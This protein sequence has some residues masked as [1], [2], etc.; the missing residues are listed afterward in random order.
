MK[1]HPIIPSDGVEAT[2]DRRTVH[3][4]RHG[5]C[6][7]AVRIP[8]VEPGICSTKPG[9]CFIFKMHVRV[10]TIV[11]PIVE[12]S[13]LQDWYTLFCCFLVMYCIVC[14]IL[15]CMYC[16]DAV[17]C[18]GSLLYDVGRKF[19]FVPKYVAF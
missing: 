8:C 1:L 18:N 10:N 5:S 11:A 15:Y 2:K 9:I 13:K 16:I 7:P 12:L 4:V 6:L 17:S 19:V 14:I 3:N